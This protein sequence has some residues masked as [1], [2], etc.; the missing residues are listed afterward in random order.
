MAYMRSNVALVIFLINLI[1]FFL[2]LFFNFKQMKVLHFANINIINNKNYSQNLRGAKEKLIKLNPNYS[3]YEIK[4]L[5]TQ[6]VLRKLTRSS[7]IEAF[8][9]YFDFA[10][11]FFLIIFSF[12]FCV[13]E[14]ECCNS[15]PNIR[16]NFAIG[17][18]YGT[19]I[20]CSDCNCRGGLGDCILCDDCVK[21]GSAL[22]NLLFV[23]F[24][25]LLFFSQLED[26]ENIFR[27]LFVL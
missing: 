20:C 19:C 1:V 27:E 15:D 9:F 22:G 24:F 14:N 12:S 2:I 6:N 18:C 11:I 13:T 23:F 25:L 26:V 17:S 16:K 4:P 7:D 8:I 5:K 21:V 10:C 3:N